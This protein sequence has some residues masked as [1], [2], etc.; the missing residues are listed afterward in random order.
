M[1]VVARQGLKFYRTYFSPQFSRKWGSTLFQKIFSDVT[2]TTFSG[3]EFQF[4]HTLFEETNFLMS[5]WN[6]FLYNFSMGEED[7]LLSPVAK[8]KEIIL[9]D[10]I[11][12]ICYA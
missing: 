11:Q 3:K 12:V 2:L 6:L 7:P 10:T 4:S 1:P 9:M 8:V 5:K